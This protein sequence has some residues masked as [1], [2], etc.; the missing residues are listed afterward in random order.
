MASEHAPTIAAATGW[1]VINSLPWSSIERGNSF[2]RTFT[3][4]YQLR[5]KRE[6][7]FHDLFLGNRDRAPLRAVPLGK[8]ALVAG[9]GRPLHPERVAFEPVGVK[10]PSHRP[11]IHDFPARLTGLAERQ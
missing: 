10:V 7:A 3:L 9:P 1:A 2:Q 11:G 6:L 4:R 8:L 5:Q